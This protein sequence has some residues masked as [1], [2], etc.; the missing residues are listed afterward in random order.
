M[1]ACRYAI[2]ALKASVPIWKRE[3]RDDGTVWIDR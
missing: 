1:A 3:H 2:D